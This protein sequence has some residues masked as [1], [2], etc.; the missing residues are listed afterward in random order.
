MIALIGGLF[1]YFIHKQNY[2]LLPFTMGFILGPFIEVNFYQAFQ[3]GLETYSIF[4]DSAVSIVLILLCVAVVAV[5]PWLRRRV[6]RE[7]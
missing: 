7:V 2:E 1:G 5:G 3:V 6:M 4:F